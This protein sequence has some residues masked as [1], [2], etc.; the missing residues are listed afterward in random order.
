MKF[1]KANLGDCHSL[2]EIHLKAFQGF[3]LTTLGKN[4]LKTYYKAS[5]KSREAIVVVA[6]DEI[7][8]QTVGFAS[9]CVLSSGYHKR[10]LKSNL[11][12]FLVS[13]SKIAITGPL[14]ITRLIKNLDK[15]TTANDDGQ[16]AELLSIGVLPEFTGKGIGRTLLA[17]FENNAKGQGAQ[18]LALT[19]DYCNNDSV[20]TFYKHNG[21][22]VYNTF[23]TY[24]ER[25]M[26]KLIKV[27]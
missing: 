3:F 25:K 10:L 2:A 13:L 4:F 15:K 5:I 16:Y 18:K 24:P 20:L 19:T 26:Y 14:A 17:E 7:K 8:N 21:F 1:R 6:F 23:I 9:G 27:L 12:P 22:E 11:L